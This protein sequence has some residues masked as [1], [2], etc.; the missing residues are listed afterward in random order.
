[1][2]IIY[3]LSLTLAITGCAMTPGQSQ[4]DRLALQARVRDTIPVCTSPT[5]CQNKWEAAQVWIIKNAGY[6]IQTATSAVIE[7]YNAVGGSTEFHMLL[8]KESIGDGK[9][10]LNLA[11][12]C[13]NMFGCKKEPYQA[14]MDFNNYINGIK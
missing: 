14:I 4:V 10:Q 1:M 11:V 5:E 6:K 2:K 12:N 7:T 8:L 9:Y 13:D 3:A